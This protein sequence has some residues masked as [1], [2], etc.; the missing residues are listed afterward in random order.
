MRKFNI[1]DRVKVLDGSRRGQTGTVS[2]VQ[3]ADPEQ[4]GIE[5]DVHSYDNHS[6]A[7][8]SLKEGDYPKYGHGWWVTTSFLQKIEEEATKTTFKVGD[9]VTYLLKGGPERLSGTVKYKDPSDILYT[10]LVEFDKEFEEGHDGDVTGVT[11]HNKR[12]WWCCA[13]DIKKEESMEKEYKVGDK[14]RITKS[15]LYYVEVFDVGKTGVINAID[16][17]NRPYQVTL[18]TPNSG[19]SYIWCKSD[20]IEAVAE[21]KL[22]V[23]DK[24]RITEGARG[25]HNVYID[26]VGTIIQHD[27]S[28]VPYQ[29]KISADIYLWCAENMVELVPEFTFMQKVWGKD[30]DDYIKGNFIS[31]LPDGRYLVDYS[32]EDEYDTGSSYDFYVEDTLF[33][34]DPTETE[35]KKMTVSEVCKALGYDVEIVK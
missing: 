15:D 14:V 32:E 24:V 23:G 21:Q 33:A 12:G 34:K 4:V 18:D 30:R 13:S 22:K 11:I 19:Y 2:C 5:L 6:C 10:Y 1:G 35:T 20:M 29:V 31:T 7:G 8:F 26:K 28:S 17:S 9:R 25:H 3:C 16:S 27:G